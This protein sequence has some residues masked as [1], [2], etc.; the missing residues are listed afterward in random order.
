MGGSWRLV[1]VVERVLD[2]QSHLA[3][4]APCGYACLSVLCS[5]AKSVQRRRVVS[6]S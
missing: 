3:K 1:D 4:Q 2:R 5:E 6:P